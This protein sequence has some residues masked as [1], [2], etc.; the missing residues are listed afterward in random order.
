MVALAQPPDVEQLIR[1][2]TSAV[3]RKRQLFKPYKDLELPEDLV[4]HCMPRAMQMHQKFDGDR[5]QYSTWITRGV[6]FA[7]L[8]YLKSRRGEQRKVDTL[9][10]ELRPQA[11]AEDG[12]LEVIRDWFTAGCPTPP[13]APNLTL[14]DWAANVYRQARKVFP[15]RSGRRGRSWFA[16][17][18][19]VTI[20]ILMRRK[21]LSTRGCRDLLE[22]N[23]EL[24]QAIGI[25]KRRNIPDQCWF[26]RAAQRAEQYLRAP[27]VDENRAA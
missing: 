13:D 2:V 14:I 6:N 11:E 10:G 9:E 17:A 21:K 26:A 3:L 22:M 5:A 1:I 4:Q 23:Q 8:D 25:T 18:Q 16:P 19:V 20:A 15:D 7:L 27:N 12:A 24:R